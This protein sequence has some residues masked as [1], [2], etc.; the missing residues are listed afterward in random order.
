M[1][2]LPAKVY[3]EADLLAVTA[4]WPYFIFGVTYKSVRPIRAKLCFMQ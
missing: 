3:K 4:P 2:H 1:S